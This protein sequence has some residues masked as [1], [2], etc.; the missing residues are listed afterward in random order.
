MR[1]LRRC[2][3]RW[4]SARRERT[5]DRCGWRHSA[6][7]R[8]ASRAPC[9]L[10]ARRIRNSVLP[11]AGIGGGAEVDVQGALRIDLERMHGMV[12]GERQP[13]NDDLGRAGRRDR[14]RRQGVADD[15]VVG[16]REQR[17][18]INCDSRPAGIAALGSRAEAND[19]VGAAAAG[20][21]LQ[22]QQE[23][24]VRRL[25]VLGVGV[26]AAAPGV[27]VDHA[28]RGNDHMPGVADIV[29]EHGGAE[30]GRQRNPAIV[31]RA[32]APGIGGRVARILRGGWLNAHQQQAGDR[33]RHRGE[34]HR[35][36][37][38]R[39]IRS[40]DIRLRLTRS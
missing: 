38:G 21:V 24:A 30:S 27:D 35:R 11:L 20:R 26:I 32:G 9:T 18:V 37:S 19:L 7:C 13:R 2:A 10:D 29:G 6:R 15:A 8:P 14:A 12:A 39:C 31:S 5:A 33:Q 23:A 22:R 36:C 40:H 16:L 17:A 3:A 25:G 34:S 1:C 28:V 4:R